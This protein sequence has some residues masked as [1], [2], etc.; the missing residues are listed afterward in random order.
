MGPTSDGRRITVWVFGV[1]RVRWP[2]SGRH[3]ET[4]RLAR[5]RSLH[6]RRFEPLSCDELVKAMGGA[7]VS[8][9]PVSRM[10]EETNE[11]VKPCLDSPRE[12]DWLYNWP[13]AT[14]VKVRCNHRIVSVAAIVAVGATISAET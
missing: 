8:K 10:C 4:A 5:V 7:A 3:V 13:D 9:S 2:I 1:F 14:D 12:G 11:R 6:A